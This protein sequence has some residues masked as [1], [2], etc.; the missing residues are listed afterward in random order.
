ML[1]AIERGQQRRVLIDSRRDC[2]DRGGEIVGLAGEED[3]VIAEAQL[4]REYGGDR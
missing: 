4:R 1:Y 2:L 3:E